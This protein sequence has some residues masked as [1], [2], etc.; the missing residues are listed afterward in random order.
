LSPSSLPSICFYTFLNSLHTVNSINISPD[1]ALVSCGLSDSTVR[2]YDLRDPTIRQSTNPQAAST[3]REGKEDLEATGG[4][5]DQDVDMMGSTSVISGSTIINKRLGDENTKLRQDTRR[6]QQASNRLISWPRSSSSCSVVFSVPAYTK[7][8]GHSGP[9]YSTSLSPEGQYLLSGSEDCTVRLWHLETKKN[10]VVYKGHNYPVWNVAFAPLGYYFATG[11]HDTTA[12]LWSTNHIAPLRMFVGHNSDVDVV[13]FHPNCNYIATGSR[14]AIHISR[15]HALAFHPLVAH[16]TLLLL[17]SLSCSDSTARLWDIQT[18]ECVRLFAGH[19]GGVRSLAMDPEGRYA[20]TGGEDGKVMIWDL[21]TGRQVTSYQA[22]TAPV[23]SID[24]SA[25]G[26]I[27]AS[28]SLDYSIQLMEPKK[29][30][31]TQPI[32]TFHTKRTPVHYLSFTPRNLLLAAG[33]FNA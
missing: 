1:A 29:P 6:A 33:V 17:A 15:Q 4:L 28:G 5:I 25:D 30:H 24:Y 18:G 27:V 11:S 13:K 9:V 2:L 19:T 3:A 20:A 10:L 7:L 14:S 16:C 8:V 21:G 31:I 22:H 26:E 32:R 23:T 12:R